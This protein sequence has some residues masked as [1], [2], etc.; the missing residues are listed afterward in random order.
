MPRTGYMLSS[1]LLTGHCSSTHACSKPR[2]TRFLSRRCAQS[3]SIPDYFLSERS[4]LHIVGNGVE[5]P[6][7]WSS[8]G[9]SEHEQMPLDCR[10]LK[11]R[12]SQTKPSR[13]HCLTS[14]NDERRR[15]KNHPIYQLASCTSSVLTPVQFKQDALPR[16]AP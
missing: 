1:S 15:I 8:V 13:A 11:S 9:V 3:S 14:L 2:H 6:G 16:F 4:G 10:P 12:T 5:I 7:A